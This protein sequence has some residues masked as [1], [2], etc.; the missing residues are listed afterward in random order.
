MTHPIYRV[1]SFE[2]VSPYTLRIQFDDET[3]QIINFQP[4]LAG[5]MFGPLREL[6]LFNQ[7]R[8]DPEVHT[9]VWPNGAD[10][11]PATLHDWPA[12]EEALIARAQKWELI[13]A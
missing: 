8:L 13:S 6:S 10:F 2:I 1:L 5:E 12:Q 3:S 4:V 9:L 11:D 7:V